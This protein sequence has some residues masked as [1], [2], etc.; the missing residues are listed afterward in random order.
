[1][2]HATARR[3]SR[4]NVAYDAVTRRP[5]LIFVGVL[6]AIVLTF[7]GIRIATDAPFLLTGTDPEPEDFESRYVAHPWLAYL[8]MTAGVLYLLGAPLQL[9]QRIR[10]KHYTCTVGSGGC[11]CLQRWSACS[12]RSY[13]DSG[14]RGAAPWKQWPPPSSAAGS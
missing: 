14:S 10:T 1:M 8:H 7:Y 9:S 2:S 6:I 12:S 4:P 3:D 13:S 5:A 11:S